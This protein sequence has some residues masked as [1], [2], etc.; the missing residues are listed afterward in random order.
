LCTE[1]FNLRQIR[2]IGGYL[3]LTDTQFKHIFTLLPS[4]IEIEV[5]IKGVT[6][7]DTIINVLENHIQITTL[8]VRNWQHLEFN[9][10]SK[11]LTEN[12]N[13]THVSLTAKISGQH[14]KTAKYVASF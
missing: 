6:N 11:Y 1:C 10:L 8:S 5:Q 7:I 9:K 3:T 13:T 14:F 2:L 4:L 12:N